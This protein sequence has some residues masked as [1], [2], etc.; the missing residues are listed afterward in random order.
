MWR[1]ISW[2]VQIDKT[3][4]DVVFD[5]SLERR[6]SR[7]KW[8]V[9]TRSHYHTM[10]VLWQSI[11]VT[12]TKNFRNY[13]FLSSNL[14]KQRPLWRIQGGSHACRLDHK[15]LYILLEWCTSVINHLMSRLSE[16][17]NT[18]DHEWIMRG[19][20]CGCSVYWKGECEWHFTSPYRTPAFYWCLV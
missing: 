8:S 18:T 17:F 5:G 12:Q 11:H 20:A 4:T 6:A 9:V 19:L 13:K 15:I 1:W 7:F 3:V 10:I 2:F 14:E 16:T